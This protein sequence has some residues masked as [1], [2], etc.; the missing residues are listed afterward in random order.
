MLVRECNKLFVCTYRSFVRSFDLYGKFS[1]LEEYTN[2]KNQNT[3][4]HGVKEVKQTN[5]M[6]HESYTYDAII[7][8]IRSNLSGFE[9]FF[10]T[11]E[12]TGTTTLK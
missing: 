3:N 4:G 1:N 9:S 5:S 8:I 11:L 7:T 12:E 2:N 10:S 6:K